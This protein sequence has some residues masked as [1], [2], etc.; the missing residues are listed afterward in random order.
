M[1]SSAIYNVSNPVP[2]AQTLIT[3][4]GKKQ[5]LPA[6]QAEQQ[7]Y[8]PRLTTYPL[9]FPATIFS[10]SGG[11]FRSDLPL[12][13]HVEHM[14]IRFT[15]TVAGAAGTS[16]TLLPVERWFEELNVFDPNAPSTALQNLYDDCQEHVLL[17]KANADKQRMLL[18]TSNMGVEGDS[19]YGLAKPLAPGVY[20]F[21]LPL[22]S[23][24]FGNFGGLMM[25]DM[26]NKLYLEAK[27]PTT[28][29]AAGS[30]TVTNCKIEL[31]VEGKLLQER[32]RQAMRALYRNNSF[33]CNFLQPHRMVKRVTLTAGSQENFIDCNELRGAIAFHEILFRPVGA[34]GAARRN[35]INIGDAADSA[36][37]VI[38]PQGNSVTGRV[39]TRFMRQIQSCEHF[40]NDYVST[41]PVYLLNYCR[42]IPQALNGKIS[43]GRYWYPNSNY[44]IRV[45][46]PP[47]ATPEVQTVTIS[48]IPAAGSYRIRFR[49]EETADLPFNASTA[50]VKAAVEALAFFARH[51]ITASIATSSSGGLTLMVFTFT[52]AENA[53]SGDL[54][55]FKAGDAFALTATTARTVAGVAG[56]P[57]SGDYEVTVYSYMYRQAVFNGNQLYS[58]E[59]AIDAPNHIQ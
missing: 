4:G 42:S 8:I 20:Y 55:D 37:E 56:L 52:D 2:Y 28:I 34:A 49:G 35:F 17:Y 45:S 6:H 39:Q 16:A 13:D 54:L 22:L 5:V 40:D 38:D 24:F 46:L 26:R 11:R 43:G 18:K 21:T 47:A 23:G 48:G 53:L 57:A 9:D 30:A 10:S 58:R 33:E 14:N 19:R 50:V 3:V 12:L 36:L 1:S 59:S 25:T 32:D 7:L 29:V 41:K 44:R 27:V 15:V 51:G 31:V